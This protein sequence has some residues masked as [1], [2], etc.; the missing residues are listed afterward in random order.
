MDKT[1]IA[2]K[3]PKEEKEGL[4]FKEIVGYVIENFSKNRLMHFFTVVIFSFSILVFTLMATI[5]LYT[6]T[7]NL[8]RY[9]KAFEPNYM[10]FSQE[11]EYVDELGNNYQKSLVTG[12]AL[13]KNIKKVFGYTHGVLKDQAVYDSEGDFLGKINL[14]MSHSTAWHFRLEGNYPLGETDVAL[15]DYFLEKAA[16]NIG[17]EIKIND[18]QL[19]I[20][21]KIL[22]TYKDVDFSNRYLEQ[23]LN[24]KYKYDFEYNL[25][26]VNGQYTDLLASNTYRIELNGDITKHDYF[27]SYNYYTLEYGTIARFGESLSLK[28]GSTPTLDNEVIVSETVYSKINKPLYYGI[29][30]TLPNLEEE[31]YN[32]AHSD[33][34]NLY[35]F[36]ESG[37]TIVGV[38]EDSEY[39]PDVLTTDANFQKIKEEY[40]KYYVYDNYLNYLNE[41]YGDIISKLNENS[42]VWEDPGAKAVLVFSN[43]KYKLNFGLYVALFLLAV[44]TTA[45]LF[46]VFKQNFIDNKDMVKAL[47][48][49]GA[50]KKDIYWI[51]LFKAIAIGSIAMIVSLVT[52]IITLVQINQNMQVNFDIEFNI[53]RFRYLL[54]FANLFNTMLLLVGSAHLLANKLMKSLDDGK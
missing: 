43:L 13:Q 2:N 33:V 46:V 1:D 21:G 36:Y 3:E 8:T 7:R 16:L 54:Y 22:T 28:L 52:L 32:N 6:S 42:L 14:G 12:K 38:Y 26:I 40:F 11:V 37:M 25:G 29:S 18:I 10:V 47:I 4:S 19:T 41:G 23:N 34:L 20:T 9:Y 48:K 45:L 17:D 5:I 35:N 44:V 15:P 30:F 50:S 49:E 51:F 39:L 27:G 53:I 31:K 24:F